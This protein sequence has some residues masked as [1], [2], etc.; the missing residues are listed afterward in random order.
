GVVVAGVFMSGRAARDSKVR[1]A[2]MRAAIADVDP[3]VEVG[4]LAKRA[5]FDEDRSAEEMLADAGKFGIETPKLTALVAPQTHHLEVEAPIVLRGGG[6]W[7]NGRVSIKA[8]IEKVNYKQHG[9]TISA[10]HRVVTLSNESTQPIAYMLRVGAPG[11]EKC[12]VRGSRMHNAMALRPKET[13]EVVVCAG[14]GR[15]RIEHLETLQITELGYHYLS[16]LTPTAVGYDS[17]TAHAHRP[18][19]RVKPCDGTDPTKILRMLGTGS[20][21][22]V[23]VVD[24]YS[25]H[26]CHRFD[27]FDAYRHMSSL[28]LRL[29]ALPPDIPASNG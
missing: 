10:P 25:R 11:L 16:Q 23:D 22:W 7:S 24:F 15:V 8:T 19:V 1:V 26:N 13:A 2:E 6:Q 17:V 29:P 21:R 12:K 4:S 18:L 27:L 28:M 9:A 3:T 20:S 14:R 5:A